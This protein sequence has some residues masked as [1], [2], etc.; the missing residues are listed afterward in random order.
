MWQ[1]SD[2]EVA[3]LRDIMTAGQAALAARIDQIETRLAGQQHAHEASRQRWWQLA[4]AAVT[5]VVLP[6]IVVGILAVI[7]ASGK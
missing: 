4:L 6:L 1:P 3:R 5:G 7:H 2:P